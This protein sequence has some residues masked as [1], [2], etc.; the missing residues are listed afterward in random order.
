MWCI[1]G[2]VGGWY[3]YV[4]YAVNEG[5][6]LIFLPALSMTE[7]S[8]SAGRRKQRLSPAA[9]QVGDGQCG[10]SASTDSPQAPL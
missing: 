2:A 4:V 3:I 7:T 9:S 5:R 10:P 6:V 1:F 8:S